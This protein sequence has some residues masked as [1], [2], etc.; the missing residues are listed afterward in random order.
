[1]T[2]GIT[3]LNA[4]HEVPY[5]NIKGAYVKVH[6]SISTDPMYPQKERI[7]TR[8]GVIVGREKGQSLYYDS[9][10]GENIPTHN[11]AIYL[12]T[13]EDTILEVRTDKTENELLEF[14]PREDGGRADG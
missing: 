2:D 6:Q 13:P 9:D 14:Q 10:M 4:L 8:E 12:E 5:S 7:E 3:D 11:A 1:M